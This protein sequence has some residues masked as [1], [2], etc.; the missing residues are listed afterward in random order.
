MTSAATASTSHDAAGGG[1]KALLGAG[2]YVRD[3]EAA[4]GW[5][6][7]VLGLDLLRTIRKD[8]RDYEHVLGIKGSSTRAILALVARPDR[9]DAPNTSGRIIFEAVDARAMAAAMRERGLEVREAVPGRAYFLSDP[10]GN[11]IEF[12]TPPPKA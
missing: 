4:R 9:E 1:L 6:E 10:E 11:P 12:Y 5:Y 2:L 3:L 8:G 7:S